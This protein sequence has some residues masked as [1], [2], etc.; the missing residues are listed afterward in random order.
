[1]PLTHVTISGY[2]SVVDVEIPLAPVTVVHG[3][4]GSG[5][6]NL[7]RSLLLMQAAA[8]GRL[9]PE[10]ASEGGFSSAMWAGPRP[11]G[12]VRMALGAEWDDVSYRLELGLPTPPSPFPLDPVVKKETLAVTGSTAVLAQRSGDTAFVRDD[13]GVRQEYPFDLFEAESLLS[14]VVDPRR[15]PV[16]S[17]VRQR[18]LDWRAYHHIRTDPGAAIRA[19]Q[20]GCFT[21]VLS[22]DGADLAAAL[23]TIREIGDERALD[24]AVDGAFP[25]AEVSIDTDARGQ[26]LVLLSRPGLQRPLSAGELSDGTLR[27]L[28]LTAALLSPRPPELMALNEPETSLHD[29]LV[30]PLAA[31]ILQASARSQMWV[32]THSAALSAALSADPRTRVVEI[33]MAGGR[34][35]V[36]NGHPLGLRR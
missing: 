17:D 36:R 1:M 26:M 25:G 20:T 11:K 7:Y 14:Q 33:G 32:T 12:P 24:D 34:T 35:V 16:L 9:A 2:R 21:P 18:M 8:K 27:F 13:N 30:E 6:S 29:D 31:L 10:F 5:K 28:A 23:H 3:A 22:H 4:N 19:P 15:L